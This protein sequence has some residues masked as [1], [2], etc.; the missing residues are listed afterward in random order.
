[1]V[2]GKGWGRGVNL[3]IAI[4]GGT[5]LLGK[6][7]VDYFN[8][9]GH[10]ITVFSRNPLQHPYAT[11]SGVSVLPLDP[12]LH[13]SLESQDVVINL[14][15]ESI[16]RRWTRKRKKEIL[17]SRVKTTG[18]VV[19]AINQ[20]QVKPELYIQASATGYY[21]ASGDRPF[22]ES[23][24]PGGSFLSRVVVQWEK[25]AQT[26]DKDVRMA[27]IRTGVVI[28]N[29]G[30]MLPKILLPIK[31]M[32]GGIPGKGENWVSWIH[33]QDFVRAVEFLAENRELSG[34]FNFT[35]PGT[36]MMKDLV[37]TAASLLK[38][39]SLFRIPGFLIRLV[40]GEMGKEMVLGSQKVIPEK[41]M[42][43]GYRFV[44]PDIRDA[45]KKEITG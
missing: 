19:E 37:K 39:P 40:L 23:S 32:L 34:I 14:A 28:S 18:T 1:M 6:G 31:L 16:S 36:V 41:L 3:R 9:K 7:L 20:V 30:G 33:M 35:A 25:A 43:E 44:F 12:P 15:G 27:I 38:R 42:S 17:H 2:P 10:Q 11:Y 29:Q 8:A 45:L 13:H 22:H 5:G 26:L 21:P 24:G 4:F